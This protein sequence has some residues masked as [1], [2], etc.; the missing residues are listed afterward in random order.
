MN[1]LK[2]PNIPRLYVIKIAKWF[3]LVM[4]IIVIFYQ[5]NGLSMEQVFIVQAVY[6]VSIVL[7]EIPSGYLAD[8][9]GRKSTLVTGSVLGLAG[10]FVYC[11]SYS[12]RG[13][14]VA[15]ITLGIGQSLISGADSAILYDSLMEQKRQEE[16]ALYEGRVIS[17]GNFAEAVAGV[18]G[19]L[20]AGISLRTPF[21][22]QAA[23]A[24]MAIPA[25]LTLT[26]P[27][28]HFILVK[29]GFRHILSIFK[30]ALWDDPM[31]RWTILFSAIAGASTLS[32]AWFVQPFFKAVDIPVPLF[33]VLWTL[34][35]L[36][37]GLAALYSYRFSRYLGTSRTLALFSVGLPLGFVLTGL[38]PVIWSLLVLLAFYLI[39]GIAT[40]VLKEYINRFTGSD[41]RATV[42]SVRNFVIRL[43]FAILG[44]FFGWITDHLSLQH[45]LVT[46]GII[47]FAGLTLSRIFYLRQLHQRRIME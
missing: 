8:V 37:V 26:E 34:L 39:R 38:F 42:L 41:V 19:G 1:P 45:A 33:G 14:I 3:M 32:M 44:P 9:W 17:L 31:L 12:F 13:F 20:L 2:H 46:A 6:S 15:E 30:N 40:P 23:V 10:Y 16:Y 29:K 25:A 47:F 24:F 36:S 7:L 28:R 11:F 5:D 21:Y 18:T 35:N 22:F 27:E 43:L 4:P